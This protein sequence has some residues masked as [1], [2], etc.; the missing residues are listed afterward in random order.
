MSPRKEVFSSANVVEPPSINGLGRNV[1]PELQDRE[2][3]VDNSLR[4]TSLAEFVGQEDLK[5]HLYI[6][7]EAP[8]QDGARPSV[9]G[10][11][12]VKCARADRFA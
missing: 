7:S 11:F 9:P 8:D 6:V 2:A 5:S 1:S 4:P 10:L 12:H 3:T